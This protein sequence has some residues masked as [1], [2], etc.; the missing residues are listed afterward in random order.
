MLEDGETQQEY[1][2]NKKYTFGRYLHTSGTLIV[3]ST[4]PTLSKTAS[5][6][7]QANNE[8]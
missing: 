7:K 1:M 2:V 3:F 8:Q 6:P 4:L 5:S